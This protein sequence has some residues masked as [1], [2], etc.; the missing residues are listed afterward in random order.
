[1][2]E[3][4]RRSSLWLISTVPLGVLLAAIATLLVPG[5]SIWLLI[6]LACVWCAVVRPHYL[7]YALV[8]AI[9]LDGVLTLQAG[10]LRV[11]PT[12]VVVGALAVGLALHV[13]WPTLIAKQIKIG[14]DGDS[15]IAAV[16]AYAAQQP[17]A[18]LIGGALLTYLV[19]VAL[20]GFVASSRADVI[21]EILK[22]AEVLV[23]FIAG[24]NFLAKERRLRALIAIVIGF[25]VLEALLGYVQW[26]LAAGDAGQSGLGL[27]VYGT[28]FQPN[29]YAAYLNLSLPVALALALFARCAATRWLSIGA[30]VVVLGAQALA[31]SRG[32]ILGLLIAAG[33]VLIVSIG[34]ERWAALIAG[35]GA[36]A[37]AVAWFTHMIPL[38]IKSRL[39]R[40]LRIDGVSLNG[41]LND[42]NFSS[43]ERLVHWVAGVRMFLA[44]PILGV[45]AGNYGAAYSQYQ[46]QGWNLALGQAHD[47]YINAAAE[48]GAIGLAALLSLTFAMLLVAWWSARWH[49]FDDASP[50]AEPAALGAPRPRG[51]T[52]VPRLNDAVDQGVLRIR[53]AL[54]GTA[55]DRAVALGLLGVLVSITVH[56][57][58]D[59]VYVHGMELQMALVLTMI[60]ILCGRVPWRAATKSSTG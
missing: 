35:G 52:L 19:A 44:H 1:M 5:K 9:T 6:M 60:V 59:D 37:F 18:T 53:I 56:N 33:V 47:Y 8:P 54:A 39:L 16:R 42:A 4:A 40:A 23:V 55:L 45:G 51:N 7:C 22:W 12:D 26:I 15:P 25:G 29:P 24:L 10:P 41:S 36:L 14:A 27:R 46:V 48:T 28:F 38:A 58:V 57:L 11:G 32:A 17:A 31:N 3:S 49:S 30:A 20:S 34:F 13:I 43:V 21:K 50:S 2:S